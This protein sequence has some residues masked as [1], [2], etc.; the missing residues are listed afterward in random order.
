[1]NHFEYGFFDELE[2]TASAAKPLYSGAKGALLGGL[3]GAGGLA[4]YSLL[5]HHGIDQ[6][7]QDAL[8]NAP[9]KAKEILKKI[10]ELQDIESGADVKKPGI[11]GF[12][13]NM[14]TDRHATEAAIKA[15]K[16]EFSENVLEQLKKT[17]KEYAGHKHTMFDRNAEH[18]KVPV[19]GGSAG[20]LGLLAGLRRAVKDTNPPPAP[21]ET[22]SK[23]SKIMAML[24]K[25]PDNQKSSK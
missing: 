21:Q 19:I 23:L 4:G 6:D 8:A 7:M 22:R 11:M 17:I 16:D 14:F 5:G 25:T 10:P 15:S 20:T 12:L 2:K 9:E 1:M 24:K 13:T 18:L 3:L